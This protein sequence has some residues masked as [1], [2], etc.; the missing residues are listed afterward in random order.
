MDDDAASLQP[1]RTQRPHSASFSRVMFKDPAGL[2]PYSYML[3]A[4]TLQYCAPPVA[5]TAGHVGRHRDRRRFGWAICKSW[6]CSMMAG[7]H[8]RAAM[9]RAF[10]DLLDDGWAALTRRDEA[11]VRLLACQP[12]LPLLSPR[13]RVFYSKIPSSVTS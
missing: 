3:V 10:V 1:S 9:K 5:W 8:W 4:P 7:H 2:P 13:N 11:C 6:I 12:L